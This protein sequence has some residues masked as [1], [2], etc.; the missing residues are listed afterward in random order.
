METWS[1]SM[2][3]IEL[4]KAEALLYMELIRHNTDELLNQ[5]SRG[6]EDEITEAEMEMTAKENYEINLK[7]EADKVPDLEAEIKQLRAKIDSINLAS[8]SNK[9]KIPIKKDSAPKKRRGRPVLDDLP[10]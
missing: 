2:I 9:I 7:N 5:I 4:T 8:K 10:F 6:I 1:K 3:E